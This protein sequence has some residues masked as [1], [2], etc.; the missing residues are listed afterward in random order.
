MLTHILIIFIILRFAVSIL[1]CLRLLFK[2]K[3]IHCDLKPE[4]VLLKQR[5]SAA[6]KVIDFGSSCFENQKGTSILYTAYMRKKSGLFQWVWVFFVLSIYLFYNV[7]NKTR[8]ALS[9]LQQIL[10]IQQAIYTH[11]DQYYQKCSVI[12][13]VTLCIC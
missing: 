12:F 3:I 13:L 8:N 2:C 10:Q 4:N 5:G 1:Q 9:N 11:I 6:I 7:S